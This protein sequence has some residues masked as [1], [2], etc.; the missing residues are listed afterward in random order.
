[1]KLTLTALSLLTVCG[2]YALTSFKKE[3]KPFDVQAY[4]V[5]VTIGCKP[6]LTSVANFLNDVEIQP[7]PGVGNHKWNIATKS[8]SSRFYFNQGINLYYGFHV[9]EAL[10]SFNKAAKFDSSCAMA[11]WGQALAVGPNINDIGYVEKPEAFTAIQKAKFLSSDA[12]SPVEKLLINSMLMRYSADTTQKREQLNQRYAEAMQKA[13]MRYPNHP[14]VAALYADALMV[15]H[16][17]NYW[18][19]D[20]SAKLWTK[21]AQT[22]LEKVL[23]KTPLHPGANHYYIHLMEASPFATQALP[24][25][26]RLVQ[27]TPRQAHMVHM[28]SHIYLRTGHYQ[29][30]IFVNEA[31]VKR[32]REES[33]VFSPMQPMVPFYQLHSQHMA[34]NCAMLAGQYEKAIQTA[35]YMQRSMDSTG[36]SLPEP[37]GNMIQYIYMTPVFINIRFEKWSNLLEMNQP[38][39]KD[40]YANVLYHFGR[41]MAYAGLNNSV[42]SEM[43]LKQLQ[44]LMPEKT[45]TLHIGPFS[46]PIEGVKVANDLLQGF[47]KMKQN[48]LDQAIEHF[49][50]AVAFDDSIAYHEPRD[51]LLNSRQYLGAAHLKA[52]Q[53]ENAASAFKRDLERN[54]D[55]IWSLYGLYQALTLQNKKADA[56]RIKKKFDKAAV[57]N[58]IDFS[59]LTLLTANVK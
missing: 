19:L 9:I 49:S 32:I 14:D 17:W 40:V 25:A 41:G 51:W 46:A 50:R 44:D 1:M 34:A 8:D 15:Q 45:L 30:S 37:L 13:Y 12:S 59:K 36:L 3:E 54:A 58:S 57:K 38:P 53:A 11:W 21:P 10:A 29:K 7:M 6:D 52:K 2:I 4:K 28:P 33:A 22:V 39:S 31:S 56:G 42:K 35:L 18:N 43:E 47:I 26:D 24:S 23:A 27:L 16:P 55:N 48:M 5:G 20:G